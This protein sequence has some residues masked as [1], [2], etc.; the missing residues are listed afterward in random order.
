MHNAARVRAFARAQ[1]CLAKTD[2]LDAAV[3]SAFGGA[4][5]PESD[6]PPTES[7]AALEALVVRR[8]QLKELVV[9]ETRRTEHH[10]HAAVKKAAARLQRQ[11]AAHL[12]TIAAEIAALRMAP[13][14]QA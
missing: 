6:T 4:M 2:A 1:G 5:Q 12:E 10:E 9:L 8:D 14:R 7:E 11:L 13:R 3:L